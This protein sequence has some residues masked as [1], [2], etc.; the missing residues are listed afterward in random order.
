MNKPNPNKC[1]VHPVGHI[2]YYNE[3]QSDATQD[4][5]SCDCTF[6]IISYKKACN[7]PE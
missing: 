2:F 3:T 5:Y 7:C 6:K 1:P 4:V